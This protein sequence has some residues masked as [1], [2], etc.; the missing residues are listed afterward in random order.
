[1][2]RFLIIGYGNPLRRDDGF[3]WRVAQ[4][5]E[6][7]YANPNVEI[8][9]CHQLMPE[10][11]EPLSRARYAIFVDA[12]AGKARCE[13]SY[14]KVEADGAAGAIFSHHVSIPALLANAEL[15][16]SAQPIETYLASVSGCDFEC[17]ESLSE[18]VARL[19]PIAVE[20]INSLINEPSL[21]SLM[22][23]APEQIRLH[24]EISMNGATYA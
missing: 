13:L 1:M 9:T 8:I 21:E 19:V 12:S 11:A 4:Q 2:S 17:G 24:A 6:S 15:L 22:L 23:L 7:Q 10:L 5:L 16:Y 3:G 14:K 20:Q 18:A